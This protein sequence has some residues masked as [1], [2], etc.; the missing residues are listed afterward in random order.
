M[1]HQDLIIFS[2]VCV[3]EKDAVI[4]QLIGKDENVFICLWHVKG[5]ITAG[6]VSYVQF[7]IKMSFWSLVILDLLSKELVLVNIN[8]W[9]MQVAFLERVLAGCD[10]YKQE[11]SKKSK[12]SRFAVV[13]VVKCKNAAYLR[14]IY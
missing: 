13:I 12:K 1:R 11:K 9:N 7:T 5:V 3:T 4:Q 10:F 6:I 8:P 14:C 2:C